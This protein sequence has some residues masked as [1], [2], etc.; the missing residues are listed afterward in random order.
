M[1]RYVVHETTNDRV[2]LGA[3]GQFRQML[4]NLN[5]GDSR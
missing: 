2:I 1:I 4:T 3:L 5:P